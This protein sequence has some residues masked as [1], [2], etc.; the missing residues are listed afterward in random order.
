MLHGHA[1]RGSQQ[2]GVDDTAAA[3]Y[4]VLQWLLLLSLGGNAGGVSKR[5]CSTPS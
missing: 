2:M 1:S 4:K 3:W 5:L